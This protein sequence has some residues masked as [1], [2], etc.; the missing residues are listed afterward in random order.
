[1]W[2]P[3]SRCWSDSGGGG[4]C[5]FCEFGIYSNLKFQV[6]SNVYI[7]FKYVWNSI[8]RCWSDRGGGA[9]QFCE[10]GFDSNLNVQV[11]NNVCI[12]SNDLQ[13]FITHKNT[14]FDSFC[15]VFNVKNDYIKS[16]ILFYLIF[17]HHRAS[18][19]MTHTYI[20]ESYRN[21]RWNNCSQRLIFSKYFDCNLQLWY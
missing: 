5:K 17:T 15:N 8:L 12:V 11:Q 16:I 14:V 1:M 3:L 2:I 6:Q 10:V 18:R 20:H 7:V 19:N 21:W 4:V 9:C 13:P